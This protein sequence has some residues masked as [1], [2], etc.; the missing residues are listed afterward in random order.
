MRLIALVIVFAAAVAAAWWFVTGRNQPHAASIVVYYTKA[1]GTTVVP[2]TISLGSARD[3]KSIAFYAASQALAGPPADI[4]A[5]RFP[6]GTHVLDIDVQGATVDV[7]ISKEI[8][9]SAE[10][11]YAETAEFKALVWTLT[12]PAT[13]PGVTSVRVRIDGQRVATMPGGHFELDEPLSRATF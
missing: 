3:R 7:D 4:D 5:V 10:G 13:L 6:A 12:D 8:D 9:A 11:G 2:W 1:D